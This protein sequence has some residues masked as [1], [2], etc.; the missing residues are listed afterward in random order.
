MNFYGSAAQRRIW[1]GSEEDRG[2]ALLQKHF[3]LHKG[4]N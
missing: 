3:E 1:L 2:P 4:V